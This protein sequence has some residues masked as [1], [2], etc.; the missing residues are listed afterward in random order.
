MGYINVTETFRRENPKYKYVARIRS[1]AGW[2]GGYDVVVIGYNEENGAE[3]EDNNVQINE[4]Y[5]RRPNQV[6]LNKLIDGYHMNLRGR[7][8]ERD[9]DKIDEERRKELEDRL[10]EKMRREFESELERKMREL[11]E[12]LKKDYEKDKI[13]L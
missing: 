12:K 8:S 3:V 4:W 9:H 7:Q 5:W 10:K 13:E 6:T 1:S 2:L 11:Q